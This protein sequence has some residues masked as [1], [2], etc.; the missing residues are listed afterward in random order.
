MWRYLVI[1]FKDAGD[2]TELTPWLRSYVQSTPEL[3]WFRTPEGALAALT[4]LVDE[5]ERVEVTWGTGCAV[6]VLHE[7]MHVGE[8]LTL[9][10]VYSSGNSYKNL[11]ELMRIMRRVAQALNVPVISYAKRLDTGVYQTKYVRG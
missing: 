7:D 2:S 3:T 8:C 4:R 11:R 5:Q 6:I 9:A 1:Y 10:G